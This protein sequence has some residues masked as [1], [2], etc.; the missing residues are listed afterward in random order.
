MMGAILRKVP[1]LHLIKWQI[2]QLSCGIVLEPVFVP[3]EHDENRKF[4]DNVDSNMRYRNLMGWCAVMVR[5]GNLI[6]LLT[7]RVRE[8]TIS[9]R[10]DI[11]SSNITRGGNIG[12]E[13]NC[14]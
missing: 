6:G 9:T 3:G 12:C 11:P 5:I 8:L 4:Q 1:G 7:A 2:M 14:Y 10:F 13:E